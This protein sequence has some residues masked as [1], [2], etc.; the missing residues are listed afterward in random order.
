MEAAVSFRLNSVNSGIFR[1]PLMAGI[2]NG[3]V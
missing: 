2:R 3:A 1:V